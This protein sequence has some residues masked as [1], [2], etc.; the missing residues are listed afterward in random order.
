MNKILLLVVS[1]LILLSGCSST[2]VRPQIQNENQIVIKHGPGWFEQTQ[3]KAEEH[4]GKYNKK[5]NLKST[6]C[7][8]DNPV[9]GGKECLSI[10]DCK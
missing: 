10:F 1:S 2:F 4:C 5:A 3:T 8:L 9:Y 7:S 6:D